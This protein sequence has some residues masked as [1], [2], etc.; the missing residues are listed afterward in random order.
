[1]KIYRIFIVPLKGEDTDQE[2]RKC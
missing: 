2:E 1:M